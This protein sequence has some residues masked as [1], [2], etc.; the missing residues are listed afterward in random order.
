MTCPDCACEYPCCANGCVGRWRW[1][2]WWLANKARSAVGRGWTPGPDPE[3]VPDPA[4]YI[5]EL[6]DPDALDEYEA[7]LPGARGRLLR[8]RHLTGT[9][10]GVLDPM[11]LPKHGGV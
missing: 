5:A 1:R 6:A 3:P 10:H 7:I 9:W 8:L 11:Y 2:A 4:A